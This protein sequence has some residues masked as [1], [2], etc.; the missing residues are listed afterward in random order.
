MYEK[1]AVVS[2]NIRN[3]I[4]SE[5]IYLIEIKEE[6][7]S[8]IR[9]SRECEGAG[10]MHKMHHNMKKKADEY[11]RLVCSYTKSTIL[12]SH[13]IENVY[14]KIYSFLTRSISS[15]KPYRDPQHKLLE[16]FLVLQVWYDLPDSL[17]G[18][19]KD[20]L[21]KTLYELL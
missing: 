1:E 14:E 7:Q 6:I 4:S 20:Q 2:T 12:Q 16:E 17:F 21:H 9:L 11:L 19:T 13:K 8:Y 3:I 15:G 10:I 5:K 18:Y